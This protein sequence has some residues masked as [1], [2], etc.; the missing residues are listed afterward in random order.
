M[1]EILTLQDP[2][3]F[4]NVVNISEAYGWSGVPCH[5]PGI[6]TVNGQLRT[7]SG[8]RPLVLYERYRHHK[9]SVAQYREWED[10]FT[11]DAGPPNW[12]FITGHSTSGTALYVIDRDT[13]DPSPWLQSCGTTTIKSGREGGGWHTWF[14]GKTDLYRTKPA[15][16]LP[17][18]SVVRFQG[19]EGIIVLPGSVHASGNIY[20][21]LDGYDLDVIKDASTI[22][23]L[24][25]ALQTTNE[26]DRQGARQWAHARWHARGRV[27][28]EQIL[29][30]GRGTNWRH[31]MLYVLAQ[32]LWNAYNKEWVVEKTLLDFNRQ[33]DMPLDDSEVM[34]KYV[35][36]GWIK[37]QP[38]NKYG[39]LGCT[40]ARRD[41][42]P[43]LDCSGC[44]HRRD[45]IKLG[46]DTAL[47]HGLGPNE[48]VVLTLATL[49]R[50]KSDNNAAETCHMDR[51]T[52]K[53]ARQNLQALGLWPKL[54]LGSDDV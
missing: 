19:V 47:E 17:D 14:T 11:T 23:W 25:E 36:P 13:A 6:E 22:G 34:E 4:D 38:G 32:E 35:R 3:L 39:A 43:W 28:I 46:F 45:M 20:R 5:R 2:G 41:Y 33:F 44:L 12:A 30:S 37:T 15:L 42:L 50:Y 9:P 29:Y 8:K 53:K 10:L 52:V 31:K 51:A 21:C 7:Y 1:S 18:G 24:A 54:P 26:V 49:N 16:E 27:C 40:T 48:N